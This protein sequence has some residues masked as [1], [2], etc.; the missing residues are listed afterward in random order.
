MIAKI[1]KAFKK[2]KVFYLID[3]FENR[4]FQKKLTNTNFTIL[5]PN[6]VGGLIYHRLGERFNSPTIDLTI[7]TDDF[8]N[9]LANLDYYITQELIESTPLENG[10]PVGIIEG[11]SSDIPSIAIN[12]THYKTF[13]QGKNKWNQRK[14]R[15]VKDNTYVI[16]YDI[17]DMTEADYNKCRYLSDESLKKFENFNCNNKVLLTRNPNCK[18]KYAHYIEPNYNG[19][20]PLVYLNRDIT[21]LM[22]YEKKFDFVKFINK[23]PC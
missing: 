18:S 19:P 2:S 10:T 20:F 15:I 12:F 21:G 11:N 7:N 14:T 6:C 22:T 23:K 4:Q 8:C 9:F 5:C 3:Q 1:K 17:G 13:E 16:M